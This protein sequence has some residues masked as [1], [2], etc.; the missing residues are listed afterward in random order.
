MTQPERLKPQLTS[1]RD[2]KN[3]VEPAATDGASRRPWMVPMFQPLDLRTA[4]ASACVSAQ[5]GGSC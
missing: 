4:R 1:L 3:S 2:L 5:D